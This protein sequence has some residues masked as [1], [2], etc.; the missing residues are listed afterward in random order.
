MKECWTK[1][2]VIIKNASAEFIL[3]LDI[4]TTNCSDERGGETGKQRKPSIMVF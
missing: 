2:F 3:P 1:I 4:E